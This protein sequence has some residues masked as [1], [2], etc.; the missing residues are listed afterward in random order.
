MATVDPD[1][2]GIQ[3]YVVR[4]YTYDPSRHE[5]RHMVVAAFDNEAEFM[6][7]IKESW[8]DVERRRAAGETID[9]LEHVTGVRL[10]AGHQRR[11]QAGRLVM[12][13]RRRRVSLSDETLAQLDLPPNVGVGRSRRSD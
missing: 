1:D 10:D 7:L 13:A 6:E 3:R 9:P 11:Q 5:R 12:A 8:A 4:R 2:D